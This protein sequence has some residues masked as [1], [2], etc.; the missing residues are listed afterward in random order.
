MREKMNRDPGVVVGCRCFTLMMMVM[1]AEK[2]AAA[3]GEER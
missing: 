3:S 2:L 1:V